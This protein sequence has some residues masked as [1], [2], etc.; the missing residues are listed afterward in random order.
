[1]ATVLVVEDERDIREMLRRF[2]ERA[3]CSVLT[4]S[5]GSEALH[6]LVTSHIDLV[7]LDLG[8]PDIDGTEVLAQAVPRI[9]VVILT[10]RSDTQDRIAGLRLGADDYV[11]KPFSPTEVVLRVKAVLSRALGRAPEGTMRSYGDGQL[12]ID[13]DRHE[14]TRRGR[15]LNLTASEWELLQALAD[16]PGRVHTRL[17]LINRVRG[18][19]FDGYE[20]IIDT[21]VK[22][23]RHKLDD[24]DRRVVETV[25]G[26][27]Y[28]FGLALDG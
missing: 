28:R 2:L 12:T 25:V 20:R 19:E 14:V 6:L 24:E 22:N 7:L 26:V 3:G 21:H 16:T 5:T 17:E 13:P 4:T 23:L 18:Y 1:M 8:L 11:V 15:E 27:G 9:P 10:A